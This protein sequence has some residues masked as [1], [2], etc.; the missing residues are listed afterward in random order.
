MSLVLSILKTQTEKHGL[1]ATIGLEARA[2]R[3]GRLTASSRSNGDVDFGPSSATLLGRPRDARSDQVICLAARFALF[4]GNDHRKSR[5]SP[6][7][8]AH[9]SMQLNPLG[10][11]TCGDRVAI[12]QGSWTRVQ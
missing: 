10:N 2:R 4:L 11:D 3:L 5:G 12:M 6:A 7:G 9:K 8:L 1:I